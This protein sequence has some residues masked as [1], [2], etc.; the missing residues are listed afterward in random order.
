[1]VTRVHVGQGNVFLAAIG[2]DT[3]RGLGGEPEECLDGGGSLRARF[4]LKHL[5][6]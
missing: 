3:P 1:M 4:Q 5:P 6:Q 2:V